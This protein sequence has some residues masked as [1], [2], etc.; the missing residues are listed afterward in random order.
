MK[1][2]GAESYNNL[3]GNATPYLQFVLQNLASEK[4]LS[5]PKAKAE[6]VEDVLPV[7]SVIRN[8]IERRETLKQTLRFSRLTTKLRK[9]IFGNKF[10][11]MKKILQSETAKI[12]AKRINLT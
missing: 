3:R 9:A 6:A 7:L 2:N 8:V 10:K 4:N 5:S 11:K 12:S 1:A